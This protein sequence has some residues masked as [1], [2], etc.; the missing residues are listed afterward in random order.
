MSTPFWGDILFSPCQAVD[1]RFLF[2]CGQI[3]F[4]PVSFGLLV[5][6]E[7]QKSGEKTSKRQRLGRDSELR[8][9]AN[10]NNQDLPPKTAWTFGLLLALRLA[11]QGF[12]PTQ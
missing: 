10:I 11:N 12:S 9:F 6:Y 1:E 5:S 8:T 7:I 4:F 3:Y 2:F